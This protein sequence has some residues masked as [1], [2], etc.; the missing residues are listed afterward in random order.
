MYCKDYNQ[1]SFARVATIRQVFRLVDFSAAQANQPMPQFSIKSL[2]KVTALVAVDFALL[3]TWSTDLSSFATASTG[4]LLVLMAMCAIYKFF[5]FASGHTQLARPHN[6]WLGTI[7]ACGCFASIFLGTPQILTTVSA[8]STNQFSSFTSIEIA[9]LV[10]WEG[11]WY[12]IIVLGVV[13]V[14]VAGFPALLFSPIARWVA[15]KFSRLQ[16][17]GRT[18][19]IVLG[20][21]TISAINVLFMPVVVEI[22]VAESGYPESYYGPTLFYVFSTAN[23]TACVVCYPFGNITDQ[24]YVEQFKKLDELPVFSASQDK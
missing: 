17:R 24:I 21:L 12:C 15:D 7:L 20:T 3:S 16:Y 4:H 2:M 14:V 10:N 13:G 5:K 9:S 1:A 6:A 23:L 8:G 18:N 19:A 11:L 22:F